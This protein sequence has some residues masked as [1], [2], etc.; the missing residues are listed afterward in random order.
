MSPNSPPEGYQTVTSYL[1][2]ERVDALIDFVRDACGNEW[3]TAAHGKDDSGE[4]P[5]RPVERQRPSG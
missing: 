2:G 4:E 5:V 3:W 1:V